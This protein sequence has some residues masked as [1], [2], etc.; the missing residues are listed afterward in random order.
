MQNFLISPFFQETAEVLDSK[1]LVKQNLE[2][3][4]ILNTLTGA[5]EGWKTHPAVLAWKGYEKILAQYGFIINQECLRRGFKGNNRDFFLKI[6]QLDQPDNNPPW[7]SNES[8]F[9]SHRGRLKCKGEIDAICASIKKSLKI[10]SI[11]KWLKE[12]YKK[13]KNQLKFEDIAVLTTFMRDNNIFPLFFNHYSQFGWT[14]GMD[15]EYIW[16]TKL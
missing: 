14:E 2:T 7:F 11:D 1:R 10:K 6:M 8:I 15:M 12:K 9:S 16:P 13:S 3:K 5:S 4:Q